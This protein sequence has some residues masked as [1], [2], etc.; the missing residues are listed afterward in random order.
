MIR[1]LGELSS[2][3]RDDC[4][5]ALFDPI[6]PAGRAW[7]DLLRTADRELAFRAL[8]AAR[9]WGVRR[10]LRNGSLWLPEAEQYGGQHRL[11]LPPV[12]W[13]SARTAFLDRHRL[14]P[15]ADL[16]IDRVKAQIR[17]GCESMS[18]ALLAK[19]LLI[20]PRG[21]VIL[22]DDPSVTSERSDAELLRNQL[23]ARVGRAQLTELLLTVDGDTHF[24]W[25]L[26]RRPPAAPEELVPVY[27]ALFVAAMGLDMTD[28]AI[29]IPGGRLFRAAGTLKDELYRREVSAYF[30]SLHGT[31]NHLLV[32]DRIWMRR[33]T[34]K[35]EQPEKLNAIL[36]GDFPSLHAARVKEDSRIIAFVHSLDEPRVRGSVG[37]P[38]FKR[39][40]SKPATSGNSR[41]LVQS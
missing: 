34:G 22:R 1:N 39:S 33:L 5:Y 8:E 17:N 31:L 36:F 21:H 26:L 29:M 2:C 28:V 30:T 19:E 25:E 27:A 13:T 37:L 35:G 9:L 12:R 15:T 18:A 41:P 23:Y 7:N 11:L 10:G 4:N 32:A 20:S 16:F 14:P 40:P 38:N 6:S 3:Y 24:S